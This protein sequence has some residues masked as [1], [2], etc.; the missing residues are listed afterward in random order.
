MYIVYIKH[1]MS[2]LKWFYIKK[3]INKW[4]VICGLKLVYL[5]VVSLKI[6]SAKY[7]KINEIHIRI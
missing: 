3:K 7:V 2:F 4:S 5:I 1:A 6:S